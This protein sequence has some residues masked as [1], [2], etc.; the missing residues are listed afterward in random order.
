MGDN[1][2]PP[3]DLVKASFFLV[4][5]IFAVYAFVVIYSVIICSMYAGDILA[6]TP[7]GLSPECVRE[8]RI[9]EAMGTLLASALAFA[10]G[11]SAK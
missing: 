10:A 5:G 3:F 7:V 8:G 2:K 11:R 9:Y 1:E 4:A 6:K